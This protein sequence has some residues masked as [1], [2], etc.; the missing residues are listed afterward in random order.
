MTALAVYL[1]AALSFL[2]HLPNLS[3]GSSHSM[4]LQFCIRTPCLIEVDLI[5]LTRRSLRVA[6]IERETHTE[7][8]L[9]AHTSHQLSAPESTL[10]DYT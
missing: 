6:N 3:K 4:Q 10:V 8:G 1:R 5:F 9:Y 2:K 7:T